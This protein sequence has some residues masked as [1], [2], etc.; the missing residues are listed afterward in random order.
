MPNYQEAKIY[1]LWSPSNHLSYIGSTCDSLDEC[2][3]KLNTT[4][5]RIKASGKD[6]HI[7]YFPILEK[8]DQRMDLIEK[9]PC[10]SREQLA[11]RTMYQLAKR[12]E[13]VRL[14]KVDAINKRKKWYEKNKDKQNEYNKRYYDANPEKRKQYYEA[15]KE[16]TK[17]Y[18]EANKGKRK[19]YYEANKEK[20]LARNE[21]RNSLMYTCECGSTIRRGSRSTHEKTKKH[22]AY[23]ASKE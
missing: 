10:D 19:Q 17:Q 11:K 8:P 2:L 20:I 4:K 16:K 9:Y 12:N 3:K 6:I 21:A 18:Y 7:S 1:H 22:M 13:L 23:I 15:N 14:Y 5:D